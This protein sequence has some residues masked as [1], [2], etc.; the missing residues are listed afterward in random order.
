MKQFETIEHPK[1]AYQAAGNPVSEHGH[2]KRTDGKSLPTGNSV[3]RN[4]IEVNDHDFPPL[5]TGG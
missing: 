2:K 3:Q 1:Q 5:A 4:R